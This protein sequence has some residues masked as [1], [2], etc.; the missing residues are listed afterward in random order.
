M[1]DAIRFVLRR[2][3]FR[4]GRYALAYQ[5]C[6]DST[7]QTGLF[8]VDKCA[9]NAKAYA[10]DRTVIGVI[11]PYN[12][13]CAYSQLPILNRAALAMVSPT[14]SDVGL[15][16]PAF[17]LPRGATASLY[18]TGERSYARLIPPDDVQGAAAAVFALRLGAGRVYVL[19]DPM[20]GQSFSFYFRRAAIRL[21][22]H[23]AGD[24]AWNPK[25]LDAAAL[26]RRVARA[27]ADAVYTCGLVDSG[28][29]TVLAAV[30]RAIGPATPVLGCSG[31]L[32]SALLFQQAG[33]A[34]RG[35]YV[36]LEGLAAVSLGPAGRAFLHDFAATQAGKPIHDSAV[37]AAEAT[38]ILLQAIA[39]SDGTRASV[40][41]ELLRSRVRNGLLGNFAVDAVGDAVP[42]RTTVVQIERRSASNAIQSYDGARVVAV[43]AP[44]RRLLGPSGS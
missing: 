21:G 33:T 8:D 5:S 41:R 23:V 34:A 29:G 42:A 7:A 44:P 10:Q 1:S 26:V 13:G 30:R 6:D 27:N 37:Y 38:E 43:I 18:P 39:R 3:G 19:H 40:A 31:L 24:E 25:R 14:N 36:T 9:A 4:A 2:H 32:P 20:L 17:G 15:T 22:E 28:V 12:S 11:G 16:R 35:T